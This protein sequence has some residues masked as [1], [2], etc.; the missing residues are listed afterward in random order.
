MKIV[1][2]YELADSILFGGADILDCLADLEDLCFTEDWENRLSDAID[3]DSLASPD[4]FLNDLMVECSRRLG[5][6]PEYQ[7]F[8]DELKKK[9][10]LNH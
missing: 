9:L 3:E 8:K 10:K 7:M 4:D 2:C 1:E 5:D 6:Q